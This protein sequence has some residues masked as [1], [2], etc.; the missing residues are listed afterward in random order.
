M[1]GR[2]GGISDLIDTTRCLLTVKHAAFLFYDV[3]FKLEVPEA[4]LLLSMQN[5]ANFGHRQNERVKRY[6][7]RLVMTET[8]GCESCTPALC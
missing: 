4:S 3:D 1:G 2:K 5:I 6:L 8:E 7:P